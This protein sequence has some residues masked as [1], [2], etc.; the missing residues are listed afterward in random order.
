MGRKPV[1]MC[2]EISLSMV[3]AY[4][5][6]S[7]QSNECAACQKTASLTSEVLKV[8]LTFLGDLHHSTTCMDGLGFGPGRPTT[9]HLCLYRQ[10]GD[11][12]Q[13]SLFSRDLLNGREYSACVQSKPRDLTPTGGQDQGSWWSMFLRILACAQFDEGALVGRQLK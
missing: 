1:Y 11:L 10:S 9:A 6:L 7:S 12:P 3:R 4:R 2:A 13:V 8:R 5:S